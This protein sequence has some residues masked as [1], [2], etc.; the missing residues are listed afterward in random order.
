MRIFYGMSQKGQWWFRVFGVGLSWKDIRIHKLTFSERNGYRRGLRI[1]S[2]LFHFLPSVSITQKEP[3]DLPEWYRMAEGFFNEIKVFSTE[4]YDEM[5]GASIL[6]QLRYAAERE[7]LK[8]AE[9]KSALEGKFRVSGIHL[10]PRGGHRSNPFSLES[11]A[12]PTGFAICPICGYELLTNGSC[13]NN[14]SS[15]NHG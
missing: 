4:M 6:T 14:E 3:V 11:N 2:W 15:K 10:E 8:D 12:Q 1:G 5:N 7:V 9:L 13:P